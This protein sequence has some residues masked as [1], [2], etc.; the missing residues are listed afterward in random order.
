VEDKD[1]GNLTANHFSV[2]RIVSP[3]TGR[4]CFSAGE[5]S[6]MSKFRYEPVQPATKSELISQLESENPEAVANALYSALKYEHD[7]KW[8]QDQCLRC[9]DSPEVSVRWAAVTC[10]GDLAFFRRPLDVQIVLT[11][12]EKATQDP[13]IAD[14]A[15][16]S[17]SMVRQFLESK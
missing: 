11:A 1:S 17:L 6:V 5:N 9:L 12:L 16:F 2:K 3:P 8:V 13:E 4:T 7:W 10:L 14:P 15:S